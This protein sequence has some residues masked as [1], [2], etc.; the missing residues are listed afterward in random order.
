MTARQRC[1]S[2]RPPFNFETL[3]IADTTSN[4]P[5]VFNKPPTS[6]M[7]LR[8]RIPPP[9]HRRRSSGNPLSA[10]HRDLLRILSFQ[11]YREPSFKRQSP[12]NRHK[13]S[14]AGRPVE[15]IECLTRLSIAACRWVHSPRMAA[16]RSPSTAVKSRKSH[17]SAVQ[18]NAATSGVKMRV[19]TF[20]R[21][22]FFASTRQCSQQGIDAS[23]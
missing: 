10:L 1:R 2:I 4:A 16:P 23:P 13:F 22:R 20:A 19:G 9:Q 12:P 15:R 11:T 6:R 8:P 18:P 17:D 7:L 14:L 21:V 3:S 5:Q